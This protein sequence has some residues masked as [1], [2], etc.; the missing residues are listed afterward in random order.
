MSHPLTAS[1]GEAPG[2]ACAALLLR[3]KNGHQVV[4]C[5]TLKPWQ[6]WMNQRSCSQCHGAIDRHDMRWRC[7]EH[8]DWDICHAC[9]D[10]HWN[11]VVHEATAR[12]MKVPPERDV[13]LTLLSW[14]PA[15]RQARK[16]FR[17]ASRLA[18]DDGP[19]GESLVSAR[20]E[21]EQARWPALL[22]LEVCAWIAVRTVATTV[23]LFSLKAITYRWIY[24]Q[25]L[26]PHGEATT[27]D[28]TFKVAVIMLSA[29]A[30]CSAEISAF[31]DW[32]SYIDFVHTGIPHKRWLATWT[33][34]GS[35]SA[36]LVLLAE[37]RLLPHISV[38]VIGLPLP[39]CS[40]AA[41]A[42]YNAWLGNWLEILGG[43]FRLPA[44]WYVGLAVYVL[45]LWRFARVRWAEAVF[46]AGAAER[47]EPTPPRTSPGRHAA[48]AAPSLAR[49]GPGRGYAPLPGGPRAP[50]RPRPPKRVTFA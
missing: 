26:F 14:V 6:G 41:A 13:A 44:L 23:L 49:P 12:L 31:F 38:S 19:S 33:L 5:K 46:G 7:E 3:C 48:P 21:V 15:E 17:R 4:K 11:R 10:D 18:E 30:A 24:L 47:E 50:T 9:Y 1:P 45:S 8:C 28:Y 42:L 34:I 39:A 2:L 37:L 22:V 43:D 35:S 32:P 40:T 16:D 36:A 20:A 29:T 27:C 25:N